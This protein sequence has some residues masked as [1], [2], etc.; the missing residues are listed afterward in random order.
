MAGAQQ[1]VL[2]RAPENGNWSHD[3]LSWRIA[4]PWTDLDR[5]VVL[6]EQPSD[7]L[8]G[9]VWT[10]LEPGSS[11]GELYVVAVR[12]YRAGQGIGRVFIAQSLRVLARAGM[13][14]ASLYVDT[15]NTPALALYRA[16]SFSS[17]HTDRCFEMN[18]TG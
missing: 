18:V 9:G 13:T 11:D 17:Q 4:A 7:A 6:A 15:T 2:R 3:D 8:L 5:F 16:A 12:P 1:L 10:K 14:T